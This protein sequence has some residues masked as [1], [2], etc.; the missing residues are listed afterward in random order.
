MAAVETLRR[1]YDRYLV[2][3]AQSENN[4]R[5]VTT[6][7]TGAFTTGTV[8]S[9]GNTLYGSSQTTFTGG[10]TILTGTRDTELVIL[11]LRPGEPGYSNALDARSILGPE[12]QQVVKDGIRTC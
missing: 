2:Q 11:M 5:A 6:P 10:G 7:P 4:V 9:S 1:G 12:W 8:T 3:N